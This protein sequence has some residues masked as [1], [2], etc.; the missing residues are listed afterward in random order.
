MGVE[1]KVGEALVFGDGLDVGLEEELVRRKE[2]GVEEYAD[3]GALLGIYRVAVVHLP[4]IYHESVVLA[5]L[6]IFAVD[7]VVHFSFQYAYEFDVVV[8]VAEGFHAWVRGES[9]CSYVEGDACFVVVD[10]FGSVL[11]DIRA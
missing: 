11:H 1:V 6:D 9:A 7:V 5:D 4:G 10:D 8:P 3:K 2:G